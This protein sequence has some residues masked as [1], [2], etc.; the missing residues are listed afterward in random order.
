MTEGFPLQAMPYPEE[1]KEIRGVQF[2]NTAYRELYFCQ[3][4]KEIL[5]PSGFLVG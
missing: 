1:W 5:A 2:S 3:K 4:V